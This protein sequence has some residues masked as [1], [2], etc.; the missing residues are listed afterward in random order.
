MAAKKSSHPY[1]WE[2]SYPSFVSW[3]IDIPDIPVYSILDDTVKNYGLR[4]AFNFLGKRYNWAEIGALSD[5][6]AYSL[7]QQGLNK[8]DK[9]GLFLPNCPYFLISYFAVLKA[10]GT[11]V[12][13]NPL[14]AK[15]EVEHQINDSHT[16]FMITANLKMLC[17]TVCPMVGATFLEKL[18]VADFTS[19]LAFPKN[20]LFSM[21]KGREITKLS[22]DNKK[23]IDLDAL[24]EHENTPAAVSINPSEDVAVLQYTGGTTGTPK[25]AMLTHQNIVANVTQIT[26]WLDDAVIGEEKMVGVLPFFHVFAMTAVMNFSVKAAMEIIALPRFDLDQ[27]LK[28]ID[29]HKPTIFPAVPA[30]YNAMN[31]HKKR[32]NYD[33]S[34]IKYCVSGGAPLPVEVKKVF[35]DVTGCILIEGYGLTESSPVVCCNPTKGKNPEGSIGLPFPKTDVKLIDP[36]T[37]QEVKMGEKGELCVKGPQV[38]KGYWN[39]E[40]DSAS[41]FTTDGY[42]KT[43]DIAIMDDEGYFYIVDRIKDLI[44]TNGYNVYPRHVEEAIY[45]HPSV[46]ECIVGGLPNKSRG[47]IVKAWI[48]VKDGMSLTEEALREFVGSK[49]SKY[50]QPKLYE[51]RDEPLPKT[52]IGKLSRKDVIAQE[53]KPN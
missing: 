48:K 9:V 49:L 21:L 27:T 24:L 29:K 8:G 18:I 33:L 28:L 52:M 19:Q 15:S 14:Y 36:D 32:D 40:E 12:N 22:F 41:T 13:Y 44:I 45:Q 46:E 10:G 11:V 5:K 39:K 37:Q 47:E 34:S 6:L 30:I 1:P 42:L 53:L 20:I 35:Q 43:G 2:Q 26:H 50:E 16:R 38:M 3:D 23:F 25:G 4:P 17:D 31:N 7:Q 51:F